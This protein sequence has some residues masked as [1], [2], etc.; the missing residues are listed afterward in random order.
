MNL[1][2]SVTGFQSILIPFP[3]CFCNLY[4]QHIL[5][6]YISGKTKTFQI[7][8]MIILYSFKM[9]FTFYMQECCLP[10]NALVNASTLA[11]S[12]DPANVLADT[13]N[14]YLVDGFKLSTIC[15]CTGPSKFGLTLIDSKASSIRS[16]LVS[17]FFSI[18]LYLTYKHETSD[19]H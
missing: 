8:K 16:K 5:Y 15:S 18:P 19:L 12:P 17:Y 2:Y 7:S 11:Y 9:Y 14:S 10:V 4:G 3:K 6:I 13:L 1:I